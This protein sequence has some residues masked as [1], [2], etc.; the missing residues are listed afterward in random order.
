MI[1]QHFG[2]TEDSKTLATKRGYKEDLITEEFAMEQQN[3]EEQR[4]FRALAARLNYIVQ[5]NLCIRFSAKEACSSMS[6][7]A[8]RDF[9]RVNKIVLFS[10]SEDCAVQIRLPVGRRGEPDAV[11]CGQRS[12]WMCC[13]EAVDF[14]RTHEA[15]N[16]VK[17]WSSTDRCA[18]VLGG[19]RAVC[20][21]RRMGVK[22]MLSEMGVVF[23]AVP[24]YQQFCFP[25]VGSSREEKEAKVKL[26]K[27]TGE[28][29]SADLF[30]KYTDLTNLR[31][32]RKAAGLYILLTDSW[33]DFASA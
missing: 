32:L 33:V 20:H 5:A 29:N 28:S 8:V 23:D 7:P 10:Q 25:L 18:D 6:C 13:D 11:V 9:Q 21:D 1:M 17:T 19:G 15:W 31:H 26:H 30:A 16:T 14:W 12:A 3:V 22:A 27:I 4:T 24:L 2:L